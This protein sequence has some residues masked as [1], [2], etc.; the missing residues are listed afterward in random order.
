MKGQF[1][2]FNTILKNKRKKCFCTIGFQKFA[3]ETRCVKDQAPEL[4]KKLA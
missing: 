1:Q 4:Y 3:L 2:I